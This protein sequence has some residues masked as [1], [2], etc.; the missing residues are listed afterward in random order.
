MVLTKLYCFL[1]F[2]LLTLIVYSQKADPELFQVKSKTFSESLYYLQYKPENYNPSTKWPLVIYLHGGGA[3]DSD[4]SRIRSSGLPNLIEKGL[5]FPAI[6]VAPHLRNRK[7]WTPTFIDEFVK[8]ATSSLPIDE[9]KIYI[10]GVSLGA[11]GVWQ[12]CIAYPYKV[13]AAVPI[14]GWGNPHEV[15][16]IKNLPVW[17]FH[18][19][20]DQVV[21]MAGSKNMINE[22]IKCDGDARLTIIENGGHDIWAQAYSYPGFTNWLL[23]K[24]KET[25]PILPAIKRV[26]K[27]DLKTYPLPKA[28]RTIVGISTLDNGTFAG[29]NEKG[30]LPVI[31]KFDTSGHIAGMCRIKD[32]TNLAWQDITNFNNSIYIGD[33]GNSNFNRQYFQ[34]YKIQTENLTS[35]SLPSEKIEFQ[36]PGIESLNFKALFFFNNSLYLLGQT[37]QTNT[38]L[39]KVPSTP[40]I[41]KADVICEIPSLTSTSITSAQFDA[42][43]N[44]LWILGSEWVGYYTISNSIE[45]LAKVKL[46]IW[47]LP[48]KKFLSAL[49]TLTDGKVVLADQFFLGGSDGSFYIMN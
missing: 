42:K 22:L 31:I 19:D 15:C 33:I 48:E 17:A 14:S 21:T 45:E 37:K 10:T 1:C 24:S 13:S 40:G 32:A 12:Y 34:I 9:N 16:K 28:L 3:I 47:Q 5:V 41:S 26:G 49:T 29:I 20:Q 27:I 6:I 11:T 43:S 38:Y 44:R 25:K 39:V 2:Q 18:G 4:I 35:E 46:Q 36:V 8:A 23:S 30:T 7:N